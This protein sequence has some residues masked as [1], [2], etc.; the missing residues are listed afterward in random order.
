M[1]ACMRVCV[2]LLGVR[3][4]RRAVGEIF[5]LVL[6]DLTDDGLVGGRQH[7]VLFGEV[8]V[9]VVHVP[10]GLLQRHTTHTRTGGGR[11]EK[12]CAATWWS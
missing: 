9:K 6:V 8:L 5:E 10:L 2:C 7:R 4:L 3:L 1:C 12:R 11:Q